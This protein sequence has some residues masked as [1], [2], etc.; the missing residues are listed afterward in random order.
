MRL[1]YRAAPGGGPRPDTGVLV[2]AMYAQKYGAVNGL[3]AAHL[4][5]L[6]ARG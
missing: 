1:M 2:R 3:S 4:E 5:S 6:L